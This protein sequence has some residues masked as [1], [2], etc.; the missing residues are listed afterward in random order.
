MF[1]NTIIF[2]IL[3]T[4]QLQN[5]QFQSLFHT[6]S[7]NYAG[8]SKWQNIRHIKALMDSKKS[9]LFTK[10]SRQIRLAIVEG[11]GSTDAKINNQLNNIIEHAMNQNMPKATITK[12]L[13][14][15]EKK[16][17]KTV[18]KQGIIELKLLNRN[19]FILLSLVTDNLA[20]TKAEVN[21]V[22]KKSRLVEFA[23]CKHMFEERG[24]ITTKLLDGQT[25]DHATEHAIEAGAEDVDLVDEND[26]YIQFETNP[27]YIDRVKKNLDAKGYKIEHYEK[28]FTPHVSVQLSTDDREQYELLKKKLLNIDGIDDIHDNIEYAEDF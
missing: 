20:K 16:D 3:K 21:G 2:N 24:I 18:M 9:D 1:L 22:V 14:N 7:I 4:R 8:H 11:G 12:I 28:V 26:N 15:Y 5:K 13:T 10:L 19:A 27:L 23:M 25:L 17:A 6:C